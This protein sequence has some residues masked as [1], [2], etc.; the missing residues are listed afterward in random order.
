[1][2]LL[3]HPL[4]LCFSQQR[5]GRIIAIACAGTRAIAF[6]LLTAILFSLTGCGQDV[7][8][9]KYFISGGY[10]PDKKQVQSTKVYPQ[11]DSIRFLFRK[12]RNEI[13]V[14]FP[15]DGDELYE[16]DSASTAA[17]KYYK[18]QIGGFKLI[19]IYNQA[20]GDMPGIVFPVY[21]N[22]AGN[23]LFLQV[24]PPNYLLGYML[25]SA[26]SDSPL[27]DYTKRGDYIN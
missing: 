20:K 17:R 7:R 19:G 2:K 4:K 6:T 3:Q 21:E 13:E 26:D 15:E 24:T 18:A 11:K 5:K 25:Y 10:Y 22:T 8:E 9:M 27:K 12:D 23:L 1:M 14:Q 16:I